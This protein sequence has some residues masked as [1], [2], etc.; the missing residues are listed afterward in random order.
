MSQWKQYCKINSFQIYFPN[1]PCFGLPR[2]S[3]A[4]NTHNKAYF[5]QSSHQLSF[6]E[7]YSVHCSLWCDLKHNG[8]PMPQA[9]INNTELWLFILDVLAC[10]I[11]EAL[12][13][14]WWR[15]LSDWT[16]LTWTNIL[17]GVT[18]FLFQLLIHTLVK[19]N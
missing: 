13:S 18:T 17:R 9:P 11:N 2:N 15:F 8:D 14:V 19:Y 6:H 1:D 3:D 5:L 4:F 7:R 16:A 10:G 12:S